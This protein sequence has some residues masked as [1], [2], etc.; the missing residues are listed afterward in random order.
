MKHSDAEVAAIALDTFKASLRTAL[1]ELK[2]TLDGLP[3]KM[4]RRLASTTAASA[5]FAADALCAQVLS[6]Q[7]EN[8]LALEERAE[9]AR[10][11][12]R[13]QKD[14]LAER[15][16]HVA[17]KV[18]VGDIVRFAG[19]SKGGWRQITSVSDTQ[20]SSN[21]LCSVSWCPKSTR[22]WTIPGPPDRILII[23]AG[24]A[25]SNYT[26]KVREVWREEKGRMK[27]VHKT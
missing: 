18:K 1:V 12:R 4:P 11:Q 16:R 27:L 21:V 9:A 2:V 8:Q 5:I 3:D 7:P 19:A 14:N 25:S 17:E 13:A 23:V 22:Y 24:Q 20:F 6:S 10:V 15:A 26:D